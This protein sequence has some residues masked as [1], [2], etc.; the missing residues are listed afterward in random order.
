MVILPLS[1]LGM[2]DQISRPRLAAVLSVHA[3]LRIDE[4]L[5]QVGNS[6]SGKA[7]VRDWSFSV[8]AASLS[9]AS[10]APNNSSYRETG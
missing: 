10:P 9:V 3:Q 6:L 4:A 2:L 8:L 7:G 5:Y 1:L